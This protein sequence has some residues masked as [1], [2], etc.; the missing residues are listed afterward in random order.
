M[1]LHLRES[2]A[3]DLPAIHRWAEAINSETFMSRCVPDPSK[4]LLW[5]IIV[6]EGIDTGTI[7]LE[8]QQ[9]DPLIAT[10]GVLIGDA[11]LFGKGIGQRAIEALVDQVLQLKAQIAIRLNVR[12][13][14]PRAIA[15]YRKCGFV[16]VATGV[17]TNQ[18]GGI[19]NFLTMELHPRIQ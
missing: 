1:H 17:K 18:D 14:N 6:V 15:C 19:V 11:D 8:T 9:E 16:D 12:M 13:N 10:L 5:K 2:T 7:W 3:A 4:A